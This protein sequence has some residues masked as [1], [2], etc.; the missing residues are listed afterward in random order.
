VPAPPEL[1]RVTAFLE[2][3][4]R[5][6]EPIREDADTALA[7]RCAEHVTGNSR[8]TPAAQVEIYRRGYWSRH[9]DSLTED[10]PGAKHLLGEEAFEAFCR[11]Y[12]EHHPP[13]APSLRD[14]GADIVTFATGYQGFPEGYAASAR[15]MF[16]YENAF[17][18]V[19]DG[20]EPPPLDPQKLAS[21]PPEAW[22][23]ARIGL[24]PLLVPLRLEYPVHWIRARARASEPR[25]DAPPAPAPA[26]VMIYRRDKMIHFEVLEPLALA[27]LEALWR[28]E[29]LGRACEQIA[30]DLD[31]AAAEALGGQVGP[32]FQRWTELGFIVDITA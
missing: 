16:R 32:W 9:L 29:P 18:D 6:P 8:L 15:E 22:G 11:A 7:A 3:V 23:M 2:Q 1:A 31:T 19:F 12:L 28:G 24:H 4:F 25:A 20:A 30:R 14:L 5:L 17:I 21:L 26:S 13:S 10:Y 27:L